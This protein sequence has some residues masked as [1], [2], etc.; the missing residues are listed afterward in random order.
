MSDENLSIKESKATRKTIL[1]L[2]ATEARDFL[3]KPDSYCSIDFPSYIVFEKILNDVN[4]ILNMEKLSGLSSKP[5]EQDDLNYIV[6]NNK[7]GKY[8][9]RPLELIHPALY[10]SLVHRITED[11]H[12]N[13]IRDRFGEFSI[14]NKIRCLSLP[15]I[16]Q[17]EETDKAEQISHWWHDVE[18]KSIELSLDYE[19]L[20]ETDITD[21]YGSIYTHAIAWAIH[22]KKTA[23]VKRK[24]KALI[25]NIID[26][27]IQDMHHG[28]TN[29][30]PQGSVLSD[31][32]VEMV[33]GYADLELINKLNEHSVDNY[34]I[35]RYRDDYRIF[36]N[37]P[38]NGDKIVKFITEVMI[39]LGMKLS[40]TKTKMSNEIIQSSIKSDKLAWIE[41]KQSEKSLEKHLL[42]IHN[43]A[44]E[45]PNSGSLSVALNDYHKC[46]N[47]ISKVNQL[48]PIIS[49]VVD[50]AYRNPRTYSICSAILSKLL[51]LIEQENE[52]EDVVN[53]IIN[54][55]SKIPN[56]G[57]LEVWLQRV[58]LSFKSEPKFN[59][60]ICKLISG[61]DVIIWNNKWISS[62]KLK[63]A[64]NPKHIVDQ[65]LIENIK[66]I[67]SPDEVE[68]FMPKDQQ[69]Y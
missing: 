61:D 64:V 57:F 1:E 11:K 68:L 60:P 59:E 20:F 8:A 9:W 36:V 14:N 24:D 10:V 32:I 42:I 27:S 22:E 55:F 50:I 62:D 49:I 53:K 44:K 48:L 7:D 40:P 69:Y 16:S 26:W 43:H 65:E 33:L 45:F 41:R 47:K 21:C 19:Y 56:T 34:Y 29:G 51:S 25:G 37:N 30:I 2:S 38:Q 67:I 17:S 13:T 46:L 28:Q 12:W 52:K 63:A 18:Q 4:K 6:Y 31:F 15:V 39:D 58:T 66:P 23:K 54:K 3:L 35:L 5:R